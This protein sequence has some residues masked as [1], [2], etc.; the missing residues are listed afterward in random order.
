MAPQGDNQPNPEGGNSYR[1]NDIF[2][3]TSKLPLK[4]QEEGVILLI[5]R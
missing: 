5:G 2:S 1:T 3:S 4:S